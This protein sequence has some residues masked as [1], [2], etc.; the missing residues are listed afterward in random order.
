MAKK[1]NEFKTATILFVDLVG[2]SDVASIND[3]PAYWPVLSSLADFVS[4]AARPSLAIS[5]DRV[6]LTTQSTC[7]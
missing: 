5:A 2:S 6:Q 4:S 3:D 7:L 1:D